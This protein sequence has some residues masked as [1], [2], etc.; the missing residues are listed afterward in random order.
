MNRY[1]TLFAFTEEEDIDIP[2]LEKQ[3]SADLRGVVG[4]ISAAK[5]S[6]TLYA[7]LRRFGFEDDEFPEWWYSPARDDVVQERPPSKDVRP[8]T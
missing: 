6:K 2:K 1:A 3:W 5:G 8:C 7:D 4:M